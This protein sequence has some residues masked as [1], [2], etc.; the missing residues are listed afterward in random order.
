MAD[1]YE[2]DQQTINAIAA[3][4]VVE[5]P[6]SVLKELLE[7][8]IDAGA[9][10]ITVHCLK[11]GIELI[12]VSDNGSGIS[13]DN[14]DRIARPHSTSKISESGDI[15][16]VSTLGFRGE[17]LA[18]IAAVSDIEIITFDG[19]DR[20][21]SQLSISYGE[22]QDIKAVSR[23]NGTTMKVKHLFKSVPARR[24][25][26]KLPQ[27]EYRKILDVFI[28]HALIHPE[29][30]FVLRHDSREIYNL[31][32]VANAS[33][34]SIHPERVHA[35]FP[36]MEWVDLFF[37]GEGVVI[38]G[39]VGHPLHQKTTV[40]ARH[41]FVNGRP[42]WDNGIA[43]SVIVGASRFIAEGMK[44]PFI[45][46]LNVPHSYVDINVHPRKLEVRFANPYRM[47]SS[48]EKAVKASFE[49]KLSDDFIGDEERVADR[50]RPRSNGVTSSLS[51]RSDTGSVGGSYSLWDRN[52]ESMSGRKSF[53]VEESLNFTKEILREDISNNPIFTK[54]GLEHYDSH[55]TEQIQTSS[56]GE[57]TV[58]ARQYMN[59]Y[60]VAEVSG[61]LL[62]VDQHAAAE[63]IRFEKLLSEFETNGIENQTLLVPIEFSVTKSDAVLYENI[64]DL[65]MKLGYGVTVDGEKI[66][67]SSVPAQIKAGDHQQ[68]LLEIVNE[69]KENEV[70]HDQE[71]TLQDKYLD[72]VVA[73]MACHS[74]VRMNQ[75]ISDLEAS[76]IIRDLY[77]CKNSYSCPH[78]RPIV[79]KLSPE[80]IDS[81]FD[82]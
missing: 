74:S 20:S 4:E 23:E 45:L 31:P 82:R 40:D 33:V 63:R 13:K 1:I 67:V 42:I 62:V 35:L 41:I 70:I 46:S 24:K 8:S 7:N 22:R 34:A 3:G 17:A 36:D 15:E 75:K 2:L 28:P 55:R 50:L 72:S 73:T 52:E 29:I 30:Q 14:L 54:E 9:T 47:Y 64:H 69:L 79:W 51:S 61:K 16:R 18:S 44:L 49:T 39:Y 59:R 21:G 19:S 38:G 25:F 58:N 56:I 12:E 10:V 11:G 80:E 78:G 68:I 48:V 32:K 26:L 60:I 27:T 65:L 77:K 6:A 5:R 76:A 37:D 53:D 57:G 43:R 71:V 66:I 81:K